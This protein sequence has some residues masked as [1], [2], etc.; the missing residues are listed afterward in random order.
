MIDS[1]PKSPGFPV[2]DG[3]IKITASPWGKKFAGRP[4]RSAALI[5]F[6]NEEEGGRNR[7]LRL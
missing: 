7:P 5:P 3:G 6:E 1:L 2:I 4:A